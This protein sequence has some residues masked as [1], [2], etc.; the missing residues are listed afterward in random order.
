LTLCVLPC[1]NAVSAN[2]ASFLQVYPL[3]VPTKQYQINETTYPLPVAQGNTL[4]T[5]CAPDEFEPVTFVLRTSQ[6]LSGITLRASALTGPSTI[7][8]E[9]VDLRLVKTWYQPND[10]NDTSRRE[11]FL[12]PELLVKDDALVTTNLSQ[13][14]SFLRATVKGARRYIDLGSVGSKVPAGAIVQDAAVLQPFSMAPNTNKQVWVTVH[15]PATTPAG[16][17]SGTITISV[18]GTPVTTVTLSVKVHLFLLSPPRIKQGIYYRGVE[19]RSVTTLDSDAKTRAQLRADLI[20][21]RDHGIMYPTVYDQIAN[22][23]TLDRRLS[24]M[25]KVGLPK[26]EIYEVQDS[27]HTTLSTTNLSATAAVTRQWVDFA[28]ARGWGQV[29]LYGF[30]EAT[31]AQFDSQLAG[32]QTIHANGGKTFATISDAVT[33]AKTAV[34]NE[35]DLAVLYGYNMPTSVVAQVHQQSRG[36]KVFKYG[37]PFSGFQNLE[38]ERYHY[39]LSLIARGF[40][41]AMAYAYQDAGLRNGNDAWNAFVAVT[42]PNEAVHFMYTYPATNGPVDTL[43]WEGHREGID[44][45]RYASTLA[46]VKRWTTA[47]LNSYLGR[48]PLENATLSRQMIVNDILAVISK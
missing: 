28:A 15:P 10:G 11:K 3:P 17:Y 24:L 23:T 31:G 35:L 33:A 40:D 7:G 44:D 12:I 46:R 43:Q 30:D 9:F 13:Q 36:K 8:A 34:V 42:G 26:D 45:I 6:S 38:Y 27:F 48:L 18:P 29:F 1:W 41:G 47:Q 32:F 21:M 5:S 2:A 39:G 4:S 19:Q 37:E 22:A 20:N 16:T 14:K 25:T